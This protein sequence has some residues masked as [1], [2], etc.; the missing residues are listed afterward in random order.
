MDADSLE[1]EAQPPGLRVAWNPMVRT[2]SGGAHGLLQVPPTGI[3]MKL[4]FTH[5]KE[6][7]SQPLPQP[8]GGHVTTLASEMKQ[9]CSVAASGKLPLKTAGDHLSPVLQ[10]Y[11][12]PAGWNV[13]EACVGSEHT[14]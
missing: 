13:E 5:R 4:M 1:E 2:Q 11:L 10:P 9:M 3:F 7:L 14:L 6:D 8:G 12:R